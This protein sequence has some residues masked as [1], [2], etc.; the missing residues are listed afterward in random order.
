MDRRLEFAR[1]LFALCTENG[2]KQTDLARYLGV[3]QSAVCHWCSC[4]TSPRADM[5]AEICRFFN[6]SADWLLG[7]TEDKK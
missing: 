6:V 3:T 7:L 4:V 5:V 2:L 1:R